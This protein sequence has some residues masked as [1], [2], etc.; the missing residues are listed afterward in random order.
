[1]AYT[2]AGILGRAQKVDKGKGAKVRGQKIKV[3]Y[4]N[5]RDY[6]TDKHKAI[7]D[8]PYGGGPGMVM[9]A[10]PILATYEEVQK[11]IKAS[12]REGDTKTLI[13]S[14]RGNK[15]NR[16]VAQKLAGDYNH[17]ILIS[18]RYEGLDRR[19][20]KATGAEL[21]SVGD[22]T[23]TGGELPALVI[24]DA[25]SR[26]I[27]GVLGTPDSCEEGRVASEELYTRPE[28]IAYKGEE[29]KVPPV[30]LGGNHQ[31]IKAWRR[32]GPNTNS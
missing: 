12:G 16:S 1:M 5:P 8:R 21:V 19:V 31:E 9:M 10:E 32:K 6:A 22:Y 7:D 4:H 11:E 3:S 25:V 14:P 18:G 28:V 23:L 13:M 29:Y 17:L 27:P 30:L 26:Y 24:L 15:F 2:E 20:E